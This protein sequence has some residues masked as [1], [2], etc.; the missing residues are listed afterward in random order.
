MKLVLKLEMVNA[1]FEDDPASE[2]ARILRH[3]GDSLLLISHLA[4]PHTS[5]LID[6]NGNNVGSAMIV[7]NDKEVTL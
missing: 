6:L 5:A 2:A 4:P 1:A 7:E 3:L